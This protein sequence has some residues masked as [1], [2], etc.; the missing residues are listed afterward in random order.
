VLTRHLSSYHRAET[1][2]FTRGQFQARIHTERTKSEQNFRDSVDVKKQQRQSSPKG[3]VPFTGSPSKS[4]NTSHPSRGSD[5]GC[6]QADLKSTG[7]D[8]L[9]YCFAAN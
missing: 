3:D 1:T 9:L 4:W 7:G 5:G 6:S 2:Q 8:G